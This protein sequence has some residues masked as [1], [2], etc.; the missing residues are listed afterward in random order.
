MHNK[1]VQKMCGTK[2]EIEKNVHVGYKGQDFERKELPCL[3]KPSDHPRYS[4]YI[5]PYY[6]FDND[7]TL[8]Y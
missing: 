4:Q 7:K 2:V 1:G 6:P 3:Q 5:T 8:D